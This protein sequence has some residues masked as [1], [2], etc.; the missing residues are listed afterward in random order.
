VALGVADGCGSADEEGCAQR[1][2]Y[3]KKTDG[4][5]PLIDVSHFGFFKVLPCI[6][7]WHR[8]Y[9]Q[10][11]PEFALKPSSFPQSPHACHRV[12]QLVM[13]LGAITA[14]QGCLTH[15]KTLTPL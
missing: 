3:A 14:L 4:T 13:P 10:L 6:P 1:K 15:K 8:S 2:E 12:S 7:T 11:T 5:V 9:F